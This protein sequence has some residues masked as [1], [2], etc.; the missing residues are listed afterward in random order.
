MLKFS[1]KSSCRPSITHE[2]I[3][4]IQIRDNRGRK[5][6]TSPMKAKSETMNF[7][8]LVEK[9]HSSWP[10]FCVEFTT[11]LVFCLS[12]YKNI[13]VCLGKSENWAKL[14]FLVFSEDYK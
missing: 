11:E 7:R 9:K 12:I 1:R 8:V 10:S 13:F 2:E 4:H 5:P 3:I 6:Q 14:A